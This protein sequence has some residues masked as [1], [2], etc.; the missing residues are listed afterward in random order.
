MSKELF[1][2]MSGSESTDAG[3]SSL[4]KGCQKW[5]GIFCQV[6]LVLILIAVGAASASAKT[7]YVQSTAD[8][9]NT[10]ILPSALTLKDAILYA[11]ATAEPDV[12]VLQNCET[13]LVSTPLS[14][15]NAFQII[16]TPIHIIGNG[17]VIVRFLNTFPFRFFQVDPT[18]DLTLEN[19]TLRFGSVN[20]SK[21]GAILN[22]GKLRVLN[23]IL[24]DNSSSSGDGGA[25]ANSNANS[26]T[27]TVV[28][29]HRSTIRNNRAFFY[30]GGLYSE[31]GDEIPLSPNKVVTLTITESSFINNHFVDQGGGLYLY[32]AHNL[33]VRDTTISGNQARDSGGGIELNG[34]PG[35]DA[36]GTVLTTFLRNVTVANNVA[37]VGGGISSEA[38][39][40]VILTNSIVAGNFANISNSNIYAASGVVLFS[41]VSG[42][43]NIIGTGFSDF[44]PSPTDIT[45]VTASTFAVNY[46]PLTTNGNAGAEH[47]RPHMSSIGVD[48]GTAGSPNDQLGFNRVG[49]AVDIGAVEFRFPV[50]APE[51]IVGWWY[52]D[53]QTGNISNDLANFFNN[54]FNNKGIWI[55]G[56]TP[57]PGMVDGALSF[58][59][60]NQYVRVSNHPE[61]NF[62]GDCNDDSAEA[63][64]IDA[65][66]K[67]CATG[68]Q[69]I[70]DKRRFT[71]SGGIF[72]NSVKGYSLF[73]FNGRLG[74]QLAHGAGH[75]FCGSPGSSCMNYVAPSTSPS[76]N[77]NRWHFVAVTVSR[78]RGAEGKMYIDGNEIHTFNPLFGDISNTADL[79][80]GGG[81]SNG[82]VVNS[83]FEGS[84]DE[85]EIFKSILTPEE[86]KGIYDAGW[87]G[88]FKFRIR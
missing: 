7:F 78:C 10:S 55:N 54:G 46:S 76:L 60:F 22:Y 42:G 83:F 35:K 30:G 28:I 17:S 88:K 63:Y 77:D 40:K 5:T 4:T 82:N 25:I 85:V 13:Y 47:H 33:I 57:S 15:N 70:V 24:E 53:E 44:T 52:L 81:Y 65:W 50:G 59:G 8:K 37:D 14:P 29:I 56:P 6:S 9:F 11:E 31:G 12:I 51:N 49:T 16:K 43:Y 73:I 19:L 39:A 23:S 86:I 80:I 67:T 62:F 68:L 36:N 69:V 79:L 74:F 87:A 71:N 20:H 41:L 3:S 45:N 64:T 1:E 34:L 18:G 26:A 21:G 84:L 61:I 66:V 38:G 2:N 32:N 75:Q 58:N 72:T 48:K 27:P